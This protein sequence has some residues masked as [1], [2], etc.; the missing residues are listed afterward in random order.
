MIG[1]KVS[2]TGQRPELTRVGE[3]RGGAHQRHRHR[4]CA[5]HAIPGLISRRGSIGL[6]RLERETDPLIVLGDS[7]YAPAT[8][9]PRLPGL[10]TRRGSN[11]CRPRTVWGS[12]GAA[13]LRIGWHLMLG[14]NGRPRRSTA[15]RTLALRS[16]PGKSRSRRSTRSR[17][18]RGVVPLL[19]PVA[20]DQRQSHAVL[21][22]QASSH[23]AY[24]VGR[25]ADDDHY[26]MH[27]N[28]SEVAHND[29]HNVTRPSTGSKV[30][31]SPSVSG[32]SRGPAPAARTN[33]ITTPPAR[34][35]APTGATRNFPEPF[36]P[37]HHESA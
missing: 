32:R 9:V 19:G 30:F 5:D 28:C 11:Y 33:P 24:R 34:N 3:R 10:G 14:R 23:G 16:S 22:L 1:P 25:V 13:D 2:G 4:L 36:R 15:D 31:G 29:V 26:L 35:R 6:G 12:S 27:S 18:N 17:A 8:P 21:L 7:A 37:F 20:V